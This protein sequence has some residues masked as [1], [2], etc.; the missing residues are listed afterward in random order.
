[1]WNRYLERVER[2]LH[3]VTPAERKDILLELSSHLHESATS[4]PGTTEA[5]RLSLAIEKLGAPEV[6]LKPIIAMLLATSASRSYVMAAL[7]ASFRVTAVKFLGT[8]ILALGYSVS[9]LLSVMAV[10]KLFIPDRVGL[11][12]E[13]DNYVLG[14]LHDPSG[15]FDI[16]GYAF[17]PVSIAVALLMYLA[18]TW[19]LVY[20]HSQSAITKGL[21]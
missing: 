18:L 13:G 20:M 21:P 15:M 11:F 10:L 6:F 17:I 16:L 9:V 7:A 12:R 2:M 19:L 8:V 1:M 5:E 3:H 4:Q 14:I